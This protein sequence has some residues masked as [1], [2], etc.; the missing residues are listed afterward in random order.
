MN[1]P[2]RKKM[3]KLIGILICIVGAVI[4]F[5]PNVREYIV[6]HETQKIE[7]SFKNLH[8]QV[9]AG[10]T[11]DSSL[12]TP[13]GEPM[14]YE[15]LYR[16]MKEYN[17]ILFSG[18]QKLSDA[19]GFEDTP[20][21]VSV[22]GDD[23]AIGYIKIPSIDCCLPLFLGA[24]TQHLSRGAAVM[25]NTSMPIGGEN[26]NCVISAHR[27]YKGSAFFRNIGEIA[28][29]DLIE[30]ANPWESLY[31]RAVSMEVIEPTNKEPLLIKEGEDAVTLVSCHP[32]MIGGGPQRIVVHCVRD[33]SVVPISDNVKV[34][35]TTDETN[36][37][38]LSNTSSTDTGTDTSTD[39]KDT[40]VQN[41]D[42][43][44]NQNGDN[45]LIKVE[46]ALRIILP[47][48]FII[49]PILFIFPC[50]RK[51]DK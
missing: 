35:E 8:E 45:A 37:D 36:T 44:S 41:T 32:Y 15:E 39:T 7:E 34:R 2:G 38:S 16:E 33:T 20:V 47:L 25:G 24:S 51:K 30:V 1:E 3:R 5:Y 43:A 42:E 49:V 28:T 10:G 21:D 14:S 11:I 40:S 13:D 26:T 17:E 23:T 50:K 6:R 18:E 27:G 9:A 19:F 46:N 29:G 31:Y 48:A 4:F 12:V 22:L